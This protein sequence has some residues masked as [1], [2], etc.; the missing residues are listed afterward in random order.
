MAAG[1]GRLPVSTRRVV[2]VVYDGVNALDFVG[3]LDV[4]AFAADL[5]KKRFPGAPPAY[6]AE[7][8]SASG[9]AV[10]TWSG[11]QF[12]VHHALTDL[13]DSLDTVLVAGGDYDQAMR[14]ARLLGWL[15]ARTSG[16]RR[17]GAVCTGAFI[18]AA[19]GLL[20]GRRATTHWAG[21]AQLAREFP[22][23]EVDPDAIFVRSGKIYTSAGG[24]AGMDLALA[25]VEEDL[26][27]DVALAVARAFVLFLKRPGGQ[28]QFSRPLLA[29]TAAGGPLQAASRSLLI[30][31]APRDR[32]AQY[33]GLFALTGKVTSFIGPLPIGV[34]TAVT[35][36]QKAGMAVLV[37]FFVVGLML[38]ARVKDERNGVVPANAGTHTA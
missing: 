11:M 26:G 31:L 17:M 29:Q 28:S 38:L 2:L 6:V 14:D 12:D 19:A 9:A 36:S 16:V 33:F 1:A 21:A 25:L 4:F 32:I 24:S 7:L 35:A 20:R 27:H 5:A 30:R 22:E 8:A 23:I 34:I 18:L 15:R 10:R 3:P 13:T 37:L